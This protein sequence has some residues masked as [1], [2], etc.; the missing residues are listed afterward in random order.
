MVAAFPRIEA[1]PRRNATQVKNKWSDLV[2]QVRASG[3][4]AITNHDQIE[5]VVVEAGKYREMAALVEGAEERRQA[6]LAELTAEFDQRLA[7]LTAP[8][9]HARMDAM[10]ASRG[11][12]MPR[13]KAG[14]SF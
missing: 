7:T 5:M 12:A 10:M 3:S 1:L 13:P 4:V 6:T 11:R 14:S 8:D 2:R 9:A